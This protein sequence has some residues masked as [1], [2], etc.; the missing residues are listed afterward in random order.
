M[1][2]NELSVKISEQ[3]WKR[4]AEDKGTSIFSLNPLRPFPARVISQLFRASLPAP[5]NVLN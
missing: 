4:S 3:A 2:I 5:L 1:G